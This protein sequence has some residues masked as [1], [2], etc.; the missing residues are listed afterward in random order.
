LKKIGQ[1]NRYNIDDK[2]LGRPRTAAQTRLLSKQTSLLTQLVKMSTGMLATSN[3]EN[4]LP[5]NCN[6]EGG[7]C[8]THL[9]MLAKAW[10]SADCMS[11]KIKLYVI[12]L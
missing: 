3:C 11:N 7:L 4:S 10:N 5:K 9:T 8:F 2:L 1:F 12:K 6:L